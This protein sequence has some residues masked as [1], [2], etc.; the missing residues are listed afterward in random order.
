M[1]QHLFCSPALVRPHEDGPALRDRKTYLESLAKQGYGRRYL[2][3]V[4]NELLLIAAELDFEHSGVIS[5]GKIQCAAAARATR[6]AVSRSGGEVFGSREAMVPLP[7][8]LA[9]APAHPIFCRACR[10]HHVPYGRAWLHA[11]HGGDAHIQP[12]EVS[13]LLRQDGALAVGFTDSGFG[14]LSAS[15]RQPR[16]LSSV[17]HRRHQGTAPV[18]PLWSSASVV[19]GALVRCDAHPASL[20]R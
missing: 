2:R 4:A 12:D 16:L 11:D 8:P 6:A 20:S 17:G 10:L 19:A 13:G 18:R 3:R 1:F 5:V 7:R 14:W 15:T 9:A